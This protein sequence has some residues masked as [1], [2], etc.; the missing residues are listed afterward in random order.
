MQELCWLPRTP[1]DTQ[2]AGPSPLTFGSLLHMTLG[3][4][5]PFITALLPESRVLCVCS[6]TTELGLGTGASLECTG[7]EL[8]ELHCHYPAACQD[9]TNPLA[10]AAAGAREWLCPA[11]P[12]VW[13]GAQNQLTGAG[14]TCETRQEAAGSSRQGHE[15]KAVTFCCQ[16]AMGDALAQHFPVPRG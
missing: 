2:E 1:G 14:S 7:P 16:D 9:Q 3:R 13:R 12:V 10:T 6:S 5:I 15:D 4:D 8:V 11:V